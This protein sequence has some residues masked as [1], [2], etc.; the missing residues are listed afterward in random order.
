MPFLR[1]ETCV[2]H[3]QQAARAA[4]AAPSLQVMKKASR[5][6]ENVKFPCP[7][8][9]SSSPFFSSFCK[10]KNQEE[11]EKQTFKTVKS[12]PKLSATPLSG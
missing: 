9:V 7:S 2:Q 11:R 12:I 1:K 3:A 4:S 5:K 6:I 8:L 10:V